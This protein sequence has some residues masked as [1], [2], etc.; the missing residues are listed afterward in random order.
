MAGDMDVEGVRWKGATGVE[1]C[2]SDGWLERFEWLRVW[3]NSARI[4]CLDAGTGAGEGR[5]WSED[6]KKSV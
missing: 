5:G 6:L 1:L 4:V 3:K 2:N